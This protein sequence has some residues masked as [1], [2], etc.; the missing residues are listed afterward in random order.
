MKK[1][2]LLLIF[3]CTSL[4]AEN[5]VWKNNEKG[6]RYQLQ[7]L[8]SEQEQKATK[9]LA[10][11]QQ[12]TTA[13]FEEL[14][15]LNVPVNDLVYQQQAIEKMSFGLVYS[16][17]TSTANVEGVTIAAVSPK[18]SMDKLGVQSGDVI[19]SVNNTSL[20]NKNNTDENGQLES[21]VLFTRVLKSIVDGNDLQLKLLRN[22]KP[23]ALNTVMHAYKLPGFTLAVNENINI[24]IAVNGANNSNC[25]TLREITQLRPLKFIYAAE[26]IAIDGKRFIRS[27]RVKLTT[28]KHEIIIKEF[29][30]SRFLLSRIPK[31]YRKKTVTIDVQAGVDYTIAAF[32]NKGNARDRENYWKPLVTGKSRK[33]NQ[34]G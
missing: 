34:T 4:Q 20:A 33:C 9:P 31:R 15:R 26:I 24:N 19:T 6:V 17:N 21:A 23:L 12:Q 16:Y 2:Y 3:I 25:G 29:I 10:M 11:W 14:N 1:L 18:S 13:L 22:G 8:T 28:G 32:F 5:S 27:G 7:G 30:Q